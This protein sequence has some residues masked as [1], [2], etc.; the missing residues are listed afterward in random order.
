MATLHA[1]S[2]RWQ[3]RS[4]I[5]VALLPLLLLSLLLL[6]PPGAAHAAPVPTAGLWR[7]VA[8]PPPSVTLQDPKPSPATTLRDGT[9]L[10]H[11]LRYDPATDTWRTLAPPATLGGG[12]TQTLLPDGRVLFVGG[13]QY[14]ASAG[15]TVAT[16]FLYDPTA[17]AWAAAAPLPGARSGHTATL[18]GDG[19]VLVVGGEIAPASIAPATVD[20]YD[21]ATDRWTPTAPL[22]AGRR[23][24]TA[25]RLADGRVL[26]VGGWGADGAVLASAELYDPAAD[27]WTAAAPLQHA[28]YAHTATLLRDGSVLVV[29]GWPYPEAASVTERYDPAGGTWRG[30]VGPSDGRAGHAAALLADGT[31]L[32]AGGLVNG[33]PSAGVA[34]YDPAAPR[35]SCMGPT[36]TASTPPPRPRPSAMSRTMARNTR[37]SPISRRAGSSAGTATAPSAAPTPCSA[38]RSPRCWRAG[39]PG[40]RRPT[41]T[42]SPTAGRSTPSSGGRWRPWRTTASRRATRTAPT[43]RP[44]RS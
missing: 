12:A 35:S 38:R 8:T 41:P 40:R 4:L 2:H 30:V 44:G 17:D 34:R 1:A 16:A 39:W 36:P 13:R 18:L 28:R 11:E 43:T 6:P 3:G 22:R 33:Q 29:G 7:P 23:G 27:T 14:G 10:I 9:V 25:T 15:P 32:V 26:V 20:R 21:L 37:R 24:H 31:V 5:R 42:P 19:S